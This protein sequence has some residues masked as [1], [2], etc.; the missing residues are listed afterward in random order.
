MLSL[1]FGILMFLVIGLLVLLVTREHQKRAHVAR[2]QLSYPQPIP[3]PP[4]TDVVNGVDTT[5]LPDH[6]H[7]EDMAIGT[8]LSHAD[9]FAG[10]IDHNSLTKGASNLLSGFPGFQHNRNNVFADKSS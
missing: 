8:A 2:Q 10:M 3:D 1:F 6:I 9:D 5:M 7:N 4:I